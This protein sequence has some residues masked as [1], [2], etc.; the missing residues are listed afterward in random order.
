[1]QSLNIAFFNNKWISINS[2][3][4]N[5]SFLPT[6]YLLIRSL[7]IWANR[8]TQQVHRGP[9]GCLSAVQRPSLSTGSQPLQGFHCVLRPHIH[10]KQTACTVAS[11]GSRC[12]SQLAAV[13]DSCLRRVDSSDWTEQS[14]YP[15]PVKHT[16]LTNQTLLQHFSDLGLASFS[17]VITNI[18]KQ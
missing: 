3:F 2:T 16:H 5:Y 8:S 6:N 11:W 1:M 10:L 17:Q 12:S 15:C 13:L 18:T 7:P 14:C 4:H 9:K